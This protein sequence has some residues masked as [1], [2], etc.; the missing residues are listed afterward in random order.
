MSDSRIGLIFNDLIG[1]IKQLVEKHRITQE[2]YRVAVHFLNEAGEAGEMPLLLDV[3]LEAFVVDVNSQNWRG[4]AGNVLG[5]YYLE[6]APFIE[7]GRLA[8]KHEPGD[9]LLVSG[10]VRDVDGE[11]LA[12]AVLDI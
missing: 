2:E 6:S 4:T 1:A 12:G 9:R 3:F 11:R 5:P 8:S 7:Q 10:I